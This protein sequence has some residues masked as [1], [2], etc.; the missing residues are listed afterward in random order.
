MYRIISLKYKTK[1]SR[2]DR[3]AFIDVNI[4]SFNNN[5]RKA[6]IV[7]AKKFG[8]TYQALDINYC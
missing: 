1:Y 6:W 5:A 8:E 4:R 7:R 2:P 3:D